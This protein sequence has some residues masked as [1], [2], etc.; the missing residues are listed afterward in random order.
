MT[1]SESARMVPVKYKPVFTA[2]CSIDGHSHI[3]SGAT[4]PLPLIWN[5]MGNIRLQRSVLDT[6]GALFLRGGKVQRKNTEKIADELVNELGKAYQ[7]CKL[8]KESPYKSALL[9]QKPSNG[10]SPSIFSPC[11]IMPMDMDYAHLGG[12][13]QESTTI[14]HEG[15]FEK[16]RALLPDKTVDG[17]YYRIR[18]NA[19]A[20]EKDGKLK[21]VSRERPDYVWVFQAY[22][23]QNDSTLAAIKK[24]PWILIPMFH[25]DP[26][27]WCNPSGGDMDYKQWIHGPWDEPFSHIATNSNSGLFIGFKM[28]PPLGYKPFDARLRYL[29]AF[30]S[31]CMEQNIPILTHCS[32]GG[33]TTHEAR[34]YQERDERTLSKKDKKEAE[35]VSSKRLLTYD[36][37]DPEGYFF[38]EYV[39]P[40]NWRP[41]LEKYPN[42][43]LCLAHFGGGEWDKFQRGQNGKGMGSDWVKEIIS[44]TK[45]FT[46][47]Y[48][49]LS[50]FDLEESSVRCNV[51]E[52][53]RQM[54]H[55]PDYK[56]LQNKIIFGVDWY[57][58]LITK[59]PK[60]GEYVESF[61]DMM[62]EYDEWQWYRS[63]VVN[64][65]TFYG[66]N[67]DAVMKN[68]NKALEGAADNQSR[69]ESGYQRIKKIKEQV[70]KIKTELEKLNT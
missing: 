64:P 26:R 24:N 27:R 23:K 62:S 8:L 41:V 20:P 52:L 46:N 17:V 29:D 65:A 3:Q 36:P 48:T 4:S 34:F 70:D 60:Y 1:G 53:F 39:H 13:P 51:V 10:T 5:Q 50:C 40:K 25:Y 57:L 61:F 66:L 59:A 7:N 18:E 14:Y 54:K 6:L 58:S 12:F 28:Y 33:M 16:D 56:H 44:L 11:I 68:M 43:K 45:E 21:D 32:P 69:R 55:N 15:I 38:D 42:L 31:K 9:Q 2:D 30:Y 63:A 22:K 47:V 19:F 35:K 49:D 67:D 37:L